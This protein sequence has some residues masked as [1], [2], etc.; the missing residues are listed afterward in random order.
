MR[1]SKRCVFCVYF[2]IFTIIYDWVMYW[3]KIHL[4]SYFKIHTKNAIINT[5][6]KVFLS[7]FF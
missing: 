7:R 3:Q 2:N 5:F 1:L 4:V 6:Y